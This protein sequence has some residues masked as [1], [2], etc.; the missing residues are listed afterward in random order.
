MQSLPTPATIFVYYDDSDY[1]KEKHQ[2]RKSLI[3]FLT[4]EPN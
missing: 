1:Q 3:T 2:F 4:D